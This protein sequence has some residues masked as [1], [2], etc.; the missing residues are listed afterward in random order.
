[1]VANEPLWDETCTFLARKKPAA[2]T[3]KPVARADAMPDGVAVKS[4]SFRAPAGPRAA[5]R[6]HLGRRESHPHE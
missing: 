6:L 4:S 5:L 1:V 2:G 3:T